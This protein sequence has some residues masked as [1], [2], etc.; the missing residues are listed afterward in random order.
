MRKIL[1]VLLI[2]AA[3][4]PGLAGG[5]SLESN[6]QVISPPAVKVLFQTPLEQSFLTGDGAVARVD[7]ANPYVLLLK[8]SS[9]SSTGSARALTRDGHVATIQLS[10]IGTSIS[11]RDP[12]IMM[13]GR[14]IAMLSLVIIAGMI[15]VTQV[16][17][18]R[19]VSQPLR[20][21]GEAA[22]PLGQGPQV[23]CA[24]L[25]RASVRFLTW[26]AAAG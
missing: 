2:V 24:I 14:W 18:V 16:L 19:G 9:G 8:T 11:Q 15:A 23:I 10:Q 25:E 22:L 13:L 7:P 4:L 21:F 26:T 3:S 20:T 1:A 17:V 5:Q 6:R 12:V